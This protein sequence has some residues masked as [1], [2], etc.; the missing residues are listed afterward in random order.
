MSSAQVTDAIVI[1][2]GADFSKSWRRNVQSSDPNTPWLY[3]PFDFTGWHGVCKVRDHPRSDAYTLATLTVALTSQGLITVS[4][5]GSASDDWTWRKGFYDVFLY[6]SGGNAT[7]MKWA[8]GL[9]VLDD[10]ASYA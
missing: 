4:A 9:A 3:V 7:P 1:P 5:L 2:K 8:E 10:G 6:S